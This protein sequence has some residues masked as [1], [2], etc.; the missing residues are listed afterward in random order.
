ML[1]LV[2]SVAKRHPNGINLRVLR[3]DLPDKLFLP[4]LDLQNSQKETAEHELDSAD[5]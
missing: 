2:Q 4:D 1:F 3:S 5:K